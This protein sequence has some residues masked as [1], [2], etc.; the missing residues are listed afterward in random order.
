MI[1]EYYKITI[2]FNSDRMPLRLQIHLTDSIDADI[3]TL[4]VTFESRNDFHSMHVKK[5]LIST[6]LCEVYRAEAK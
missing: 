6:S 5:V 2:R 3:A 1:E 4:K